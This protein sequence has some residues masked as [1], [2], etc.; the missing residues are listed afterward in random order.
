MVLR[1]LNLS[2]KWKDLIVLQEKRKLKKKRRFSVADTKEIFMKQNMKIYNIEMLYSEVLVFNP[3]LTMLLKDACEDVA[4]QITREV[5]VVPL[6]NTIFVSVKALIPDSIEIERF[7]SQVKDFEY[8]D[9]IYLED[10]GVR[11]KIE[12][13]EP[14]EFE[15][16]KN[17][18]PKDFAKIE[19][20]F[21]V[22][23]DT[24]F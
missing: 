15:S 18:G 24:E 12:F 19:L 10:V 3:Y 4:D 5:D 11:F 20:K 13:V 23:L 9:I 2:E 16:F 21:K 14:V 8:K 1:Q 17:D 7:E 6:Y 22:V